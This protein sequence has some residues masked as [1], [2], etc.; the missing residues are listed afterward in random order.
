MSPGLRYYLALQTWKSMQAV[1]KA[2]GQNVPAPKPEDYRCDVC[3][4]HECE[5]DCYG[6]GSYE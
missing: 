2:T 6:Y 3:G 1:Y 4:T 5:M